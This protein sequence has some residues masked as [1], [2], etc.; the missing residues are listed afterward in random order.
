MQKLS[1]QSFQV[2]M[3][4]FLTPQ[5]YK[6]GHQVWQ[7]GYEP[8]RWSLQ[9]LVWTLLAMAFCTGDS[10]EERFVTARAA[11]VAGHQK[12][13]RP[14]ATLIGFAMALVK[15]PLVVFRA[16]ASGVRQQL[17]RQFVASLRINGWLPVACDGTRLECP[18]SEQLQRRLGQAGKPESAPMVYLTALVLLPL[19]VPWAWRWGKGTA[20]EHD[21]LRQLLPTLP[22]RTLLV[23]DAFYAGY[24][25]FR[26]IVRAQASFL[27]RMSS[28][29]CLYTIEERPL[30][31]FREGVFYYWPEKERDK[32]RPPLKVRLLRVPGHKA[33]V[34][35]LTN[36][37][38][39]QQ[40]SHKNAAQI[41]RWRWKHEGLF[42][43]YKRMLGKVKL[44]SRTVALVHREAEGSLLALQLLLALAAK[45]V[46]QGRQRVLILDSPRRVLL[47]LRGE[48][49]ALRR[50]LG[51][52]QF[53]A[54]Q[55]WLREVRSEEWH[56]TRPKSR[57]HWPHKKD[58]KPPKPPKIRVMPPALK[59]K[60]IK[61]LKAA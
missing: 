3:S 22:E 38:D 24:H 27:I 37:L 56:R 47:G 32:G 61:I 57:Q 45:A 35:L 40:L 41:Y 34:W 36:I 44:R 59:A 23:G 49:V 25:L 11:Y 31:R 50:S 7:P 60:M 30:E 15:L 52:R 51:P 46:Q 54:Y 20:S 5:V 17:D 33:D 4:Y 19:G 58:Y 9:A 29:L 18:R 10:Q 39:R 43:T 13:R 8:P 55:R 21:H 16:L 6:Q 14:G 12:L 26:D 28:R 2:G 53:A 42:R 48:I 1:V